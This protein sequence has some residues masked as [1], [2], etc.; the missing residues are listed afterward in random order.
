MFVIEKGNKIK[1]VQGD[2]GCIRLKIN[3]YTLSEGDEVLFGV[4]LKSQ[5]KVGEC[6]FDTSINKPIWWNGSTWI[7]SDGTNA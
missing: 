5:P 1:M 3:N 2:T 7:L 4:A 6:F